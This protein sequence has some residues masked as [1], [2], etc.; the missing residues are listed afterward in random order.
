MPC[1]VSMQTY[2]RWIQRFIKIRKIDISYWHP[3]VISPL[4]FFQRLSCTIK[5][6]KLLWAGYFCFSWNKY[7]LFSLF[8][9]FLYHNTDWIHWCRCQ[10]VAK[11]C[12][13]KNSHHPITRYLNTINIWILGDP[14]LNLCI[15]N[16]LFRHFSDSDAMCMLN[17]MTL[18]LFRSHS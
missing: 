8:C 2:F 3:F 5:E 4:S 12:I 15:S 18:V 6:L 17:L 11:F 1:L 14:G 16:L 10:I 9:V 13:I 7:P